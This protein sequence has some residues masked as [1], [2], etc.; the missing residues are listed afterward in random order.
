MKFPTLFRTNAPMR[1][2]IKPR[3]YDPVREELEERTSQIK[4][5]LQQEGKLPYDGTESEDYRRYGGSLKGAFSS[6][7][8]IKGRQSSPLTSA[9]MIR[10]IIFVLLVAAIFGYIYLG[11]DAI[12]IMGYGL[13]AIGLIVMFF[14]FKGKSRA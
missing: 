14:R 6:G 5:D 12:Y 7:S 1:F 10:L 3:Y 2:D 4:R 13:A 11:P 8:Q 9:G